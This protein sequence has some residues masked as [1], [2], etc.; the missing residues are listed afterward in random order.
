VLT[1]SGDWLD[2]DPTND[3]LADSRYIVTAW[4]RDFS[5]VSPLRGVV[6]TEAGTSK[7]VVE[8]DVDPLPAGG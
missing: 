6:F 1:P 3:Q 5:D 4:G 7:L 2:L 8:V